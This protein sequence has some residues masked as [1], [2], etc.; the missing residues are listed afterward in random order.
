MSKKAAIYC[1]VSTLEQAEST[2]NK[3]SIESQEDICRSWLG[4]KRNGIEIHKVYTDTKSGRNLDRPALQELLKDASNKKFDIVVATRLDRISRSIK[5]FQE[6]IDILSDSDVEISFATE[7]MDTSTLMGKAM[8]NILMVFAEFESDMIRKRTFEQ[9]I[10]SIKNGY[11]G[12]G[13][14]PL[15][16]NNINGGLIVDLEEAKLVKMIFDNYIKEKSVPKIVRELNNQ[17]YRTKKWITKKGNQKGG[18][19]YSRGALYNILKRRLYIGEEEI[20]GKIYP[21]KHEKILD[22]EK[23]FSAREILNENSNK[24]KKYVSGDSPNLLEGIIRCGFCNGAYTPT[25]TKKPDRR[26]Y[27]YECSIKNKEGATKTHNPSTLN[28]TILDDFILDTIKYFIDQPELLSAFKKRFS[29]NKSDEIDNIM[30]EIRFMKKNIS[31]SEVEIASHMSVIES[32]LLSENLDLWNRKIS[33][34]RKEISQIESELVKKQEKLNV[35]KDS[36]ILDDSDYMKILNEFNL[37]F[38]GSSLKQKKEL[39]QILIHEVKTKV[40]GTFKNKKGIIKVDYICDE[41]LYSLWQDIKNANS[42]K[43]K[44][45]TSF[46]LGSPGR[47]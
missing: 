9:R 39:I 16:Y 3:S 18:K 1:R 29:F 17:G 46:R 10:A 11:W 27:Y 42:D 2:Q 35:L 15:G 12:G 5:D 20:D 30:S 31:R 23:F 24:A 38:E 37:Q 26:H 36:K 6:L 47:I 21:T 14:I 28:Q 25:Y 4:I 33:E 8:R 13:Y 43:I 32:N 45:R 34:K 7:D 19:K 22:S 40:K 44:V 41:Y